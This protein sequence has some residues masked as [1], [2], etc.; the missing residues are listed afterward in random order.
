MNSLHSLR[1]EWKSEW[2]MPQKRISIC[3]SWSV[4]SRRGM[5]GGG[6][7]DVALAAEKALVLYMPACSLM[8]GSTACGATDSPTTDRPIVRLPATSGPG[9]PAVPLMDQAQ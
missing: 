8:R 6:S 1:T 4:G 7:G 3:T 5:E 9:T 2:Q